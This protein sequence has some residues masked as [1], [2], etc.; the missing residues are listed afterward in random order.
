MKYVAAKTTFKATEATKRIILKF[1]F[2][3]QPRKFG[4][5]DGHLLPVQ[6]RIEYRIFRFSNGRGWYI[7]PSSGLLNPLCIDNLTR[8][9]I[10]INKTVQP[11][12]AYF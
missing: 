1:S 12:E 3:M 2:M 6:D 9:G 11:G 8:L 7:P 5:L 10:D 4:L